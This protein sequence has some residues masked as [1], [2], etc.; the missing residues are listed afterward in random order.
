MGMTNNKTVL[1]LAIH[2]LSVDIV[3]F[4]VILLQP[5]F[6]LE[7]L[8]VLSSLFINTW[9]VLRSTWLK[10]YL[11]LDDTIKTHRIITCLS[12]CFF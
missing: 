10:V 7:H 5:A 2:C 11:R 9:V 4:L 6:V 3:L 1:C 12:A 8:E